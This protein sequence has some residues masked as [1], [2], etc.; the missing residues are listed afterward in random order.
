MAFSIPTFR[1]LLTRAQTDLGSAADGTSPR[2]TP[3]YAIAR[4]LA[5]LSKHLFSAIQYVLRQCSPLTADEVY[6]WRWGAPFGIYQLAAQAW[7]GSAK[8][9][10]AEGTTVPAGTE[11]HRADGQ[12][13]TTDVEVEI[14]ADETAIV[15]L[16]SVTAASAANN[17]SG[18]VLSL[19]A[20]LLG[21]DTDATVVSSS[22]SGADVE[23]WKTGALPRLLRRLRNP[24]KGGGPG[25]YEAWALEVPGVTR[26][27]EFPL[28]EGPATVSVA[29]ARDADPSP[30]PDS[31]ERAVVLAH[32][33]SKAPVTAEVKVITLSALSVPL[34]FSALTPNTVAVQ[35][36]IEASV[37]D[38]LQRE[39][40]PGGT[41]PLSRLEDAISSAVGEVSHVLSSPSSPIVVPTNRLPVLGSVTYP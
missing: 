32:L 23:Q 33:E 26:A 35:D 38:L 16:T 4:A 22:Q 18:Q 5:G 30:I 25:D 10:G 41:I 12:L 2:A 34:V 15:A 21:L 8:L 14:A 36:A 37:S 11:F 3:E 40:E 19:T 17:D 20:P 1:D 7:K 27:W 29:F 28:L 31:G 39:G 6:G 9:T 24:P 13:Y